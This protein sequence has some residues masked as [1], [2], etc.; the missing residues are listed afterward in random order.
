MINNYSLNFGSL[1]NSAASS[2]L[3]NL[4]FT[5]GMYQKDE[6][7]IILKND[8]QNLIYQYRNMI[9]CSSAS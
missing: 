7:R 2:L 4:N 5:I 6:V 3:I 8:A 9:S 1:I